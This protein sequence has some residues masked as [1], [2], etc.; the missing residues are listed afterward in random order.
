M[1]GYDGSECGPW[2]ESDEVTILSRTPSVPLELTISPLAPLCTNSLVAT[3]DG[4]TDPDTGDTV[5]Y[6]YQWALAPGTSSAQK[7]P[8][9]KVAE[10]GYDST[11]GVLTGVALH[12]GEVWY[13]HACATDGTVDSAWTEP[14]SVTIGNTA[15]SV[16]S[17][18]VTSPDSPTCVT[19]LGATAGGS[20]D[21]DTADSVSYKYQWAL[22]PPEA[23]PGSKASKVPAWRYDSTDGVLTG[24]TLHKGEV[25][26]AHACATD[27]TDDSVWS[28]PVQVTVQ[29]A[30]PTGLQVAVVPLH[31]RTI[32]DLTAKPTATDADGDTVTYQVKWARLTEVGGWGGWDDSGR[33]LNHSETAA[34]ER[35][36]AQARAYD[37]TG[38]TD[39]VEGA[40]VEIDNT[41]PGAMSSLAISPAHPNAA[42]DLRTV[43]GAAPDADGDALTYAFQ[44]SKSSDGGGTWSAWAGYGRMVSKT[45]TTRDEQWRVRARAS[46]GA[47]FGAWRV[48]APVTVL[49]SRPTVPTS[50]TIA[51]SSPGPDVDLVATAADATDA[52]PDDIVSYEY[53]W[54]R[55]RDGG[56][57]WSPW[58][59]TGETLSTSLTVQGQKWQ[60]CARASDGTLYTAWRVGSIVTIQPVAAPA[61]AMTAAVAATQR[62]AAQV[63]ARVLNMA[64]REV[65]VLAAQTLPAGLR[66]LVWSGRSATGT[67]TSPGQYLVEVLACAT[68]GAI[69]RCVVPLV[70]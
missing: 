3:A 5:S 17:Q 37:G 41:P 21:A 55:S 53:K 4:A 47:S 68:D 13:A 25:W 57:T 27:G 67:A 10:W 11:D 60:A 69:A 35:W 14:V 9:S 51:P 20:S 22:V 8:N 66:T 32:H 63:T 23:A 62:G 18:L 15:P 12:R 46:D 16:P 54:R 48:S 26:Y 28:E 49:N 36:K 43:T 1:R 59:W 65:A 70:R 33:V 64:G 42:V 38:Y 56:A 44:W 52:D 40:P 31:P 30:L 58:S 29:D 24:V 50:V 34:G 39:W 7:G 19:G 45:L 6:K 61:L 2:T